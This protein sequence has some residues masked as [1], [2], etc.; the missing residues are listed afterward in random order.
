MADARP[1]RK[2]NPMLLLNTAKNADASKERA[3]TDFRPNPVA[4]ARRVTVG[5]NDAQAPVAQPVAPAAP[6]RQPTGERPLQVQQG[7]EAGAFSN[8]AARV[9]TPARQA[10]PAKESA[11]TTP[12]VD[13]PAEAAVAPMAFNPELVAY[14]A[15]A[16]T[17][18]RP[19]ATPG[20]GERPRG[21]NPL[22][23]DAGSGRAP[24]RPAVRP[25][26]GA[27]PTEP[28]RSLADLE[29]A[30][31]SDAPQQPGV[32]TKAPQRTSMSSRVNPRFSLRDAASEQIAKQAR[33]SALAQRG[34]V[35]GA[36]GKFVGLNEANAEDLEA[37]GKRQSPFFTRG[38]KPRYQAPSTVKGAANI[39]VGSWD[40]DTATDSQYGLTADRDTYMHKPKLGEKKNVSIQNRDVIMLRF[41]TRYRYA[42][43]AQL[44]RLI[45]T[46]PKQAMHRL[47]RLEEAGFVRRHV[48]TGKQYLWT[49]T[50]AGNLLIDSPFA[51]IKKGAISFATIAHTIALAEI[52]AE[53]EREAGGR[54]ILGEVSDDEWQPLMNRYKFGT[55]GHPD[56]KTFGEMTVTE[57]E[58]R[59]G[60]MRWRGGRSTLEMREMVDY[61][62]A[63]GEDAPELE[64]GNEGLF[65]VYGANGQDTEHVPDLVVARERGA[66]GKPEHIAIELELTDKPLPD[67]QRILRWYRDNGV[68]YTKVIYLTPRRQ[69]FNGLMRAN[70]AEQYGGLVV[71]K[72]IQ[73]HGRTPFF[74]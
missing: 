34:V 11:E 35:R 9:P 16:P 10:P 12:E 3:A 17:T 37:A 73:E 53:L 62:V 45:D 49:T 61:A 38:G 27:R 43:A 13:V 46:T 58:I 4:G 25:N 26:L 1:P 19:R 23:A 8:R 18:P 48:V 32:G 55:W 59:Q 52:G 56:G 51:P 5:G 28:R 15:P 42:Y 20:R 40:D 74:G 31:E 72:Y 21:V 29:A 67:W 71:R 57:R 60:Q 39:G 50:K 54:N 68:M 44:A 41:L 6:R 65:V 30:D 69:I 33:E 24:Q 22:F 2:V 47:N 14:E 7:G 63:A 66:D 64:E 36:D 70:A